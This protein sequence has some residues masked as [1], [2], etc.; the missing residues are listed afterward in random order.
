MH[1]RESLSLGQSIRP[2]SLKLWA[3]GEATFSMFSHFEAL[4]LLL[5]NQFNQLDK[6]VDWVAVPYLR[7]MAF[8]LMW[9]GAS[10]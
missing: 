10:S 2:R 1:L 6:I 7:E 9:E 5:P 3:I 4:I 8:M